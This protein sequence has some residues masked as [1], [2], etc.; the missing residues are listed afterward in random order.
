MSTCGALGLERGDRRADVGVRRGVGGRRQLGLGDLVLDALEQVL[1]ELVVL[2]EDA[3]LLALEVL[4]H[5][6]AEDLAF[7]DVVKLPAERVRQL[8]RVVPALAAGRHEHVGHLLRVQVR[9]DGQVGRR[10]EAVED[11]VHLVLEDQLVH[12]V[13]GH[14]G[15][16]LVV[17]VLVGDLPAEDAAVRVDVLEVRVRGRRDLGV[18]GRGRPGERLVAADQDRRRGDP[19][20]GR[21]QRGGTRPGG[22][23]ARRRGAAG[24]AGATAAGTAGRQQHGDDGGPGDERQVSP[25]RFPHLMP[26]FWCSLAGACRRKELKGAVAAGVTG[27]S[28]RRMAPWIPAGNRSMTRI[29]TT[30]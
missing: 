9:G 1:A 11:R 17:Q 7:P 15:V 21:G 29:S 26:S 23:G 24:A 22:A 6:V 5:V 12:H 16:V 10:A 13:R 20:R 30:P 28:R 18:A 25:S 14:R 27:P 19:R 8:G 2:V 3:D 4:L